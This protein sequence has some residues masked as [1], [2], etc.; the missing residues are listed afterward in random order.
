MDPRARFAACGRPRLCGEPHRAGDPVPSRGAQERR[1]CGLPLGPRAQARTSEEG[2]RSVTARCLPA[3]ARLAAYD[4]KA[5]EGQ[6]DS[7][8]CV[9][10]PKLLSA[11]ECADIASLYADERRFRSHVVMARHGFGRGEY[12]YFKYPLPDLLGDLRTALYPRFV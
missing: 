11:H 1:S 12:R 2:I 5:I 3:E 10:L 6:L 8:G 4:W 7:T 9:V